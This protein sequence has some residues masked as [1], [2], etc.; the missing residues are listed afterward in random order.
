MTGWPC[1]K[2]VLLHCAEVGSNRT[3]LFHYSYYR[4]EQERIHGKKSNDKQKNHYQN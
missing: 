3:N 1:V 4:K 2:I